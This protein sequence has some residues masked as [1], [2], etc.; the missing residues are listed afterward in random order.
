LASPETY[1]G[2]VPE[3][4]SSISTIFPDSLYLKR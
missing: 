1:R 2:S 3:L 4:S